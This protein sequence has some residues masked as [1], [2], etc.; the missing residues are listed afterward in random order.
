MIE[1]ARGDIPESAIRRVA[2]VSVSPNGRE[3]MVVLELDVKT[4][5]ECLA[6][7]RLYRGED[8]EWS[9]QSST[10]QS[11]GMWAGLGGADGLC[12][13]FVD[14]LRPGSREVV[15]RVNGERHFARVRPDGVVFF[16][17]WD[18]PCRS[19]QTLKLECDELR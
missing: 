18:V 1:E 11:L 16:A 19:I 4:E 7:S 12:V 3:A 13:V 15:L 17:L 9:E 2:G 6:I 14:R 8:G 10:T 5:C